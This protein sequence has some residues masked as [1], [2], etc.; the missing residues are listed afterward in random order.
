[1]SHLLRSVNRPCDDNYVCPASEADLLVGFSRRPGRRALKVRGTYRTLG[2]AWPVLP[3]RAT[4]VADRSILTKMWTGYLKPTIVSL[5]LLPRMVK[6]PA[7]SLT[8][9]LRK[10]V[11]R[12]PCGEL[13]RGGVELA[14]LQGKPWTTPGV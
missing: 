4:A 5:W 8:F 12:S 2:P 7:S 9:F 11:V 3:R 13:W 10:T 14:Q 6:T 1:M